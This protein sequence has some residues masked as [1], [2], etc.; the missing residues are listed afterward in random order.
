MI[1]YHTI[2]IRPVMP[3]KGPGTYRAKLI[4]RF[5]RVPE[6][7]ELAQLERGKK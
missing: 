1:E 4:A 3:P 6:P 5:G 2:Y 7:H